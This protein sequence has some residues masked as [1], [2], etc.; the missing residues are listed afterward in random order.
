MSRLSVQFPSKTNEMLS[1]L[2]E[3]EEVSK[4]E[5]LRR[6]IALYRYINREA[7]VNGNKLAITDKD[8]NIIKEKIGRAHV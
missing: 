8:D 6:A 2:A 5:I 4:T 1:D 7:R 3:S